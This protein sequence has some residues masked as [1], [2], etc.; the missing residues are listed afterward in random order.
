MIGTGRIKQ[1]RLGK[2]SLTERHGWLIITIVN[3]LEKNR[4]TLR[5]QVTLEH[6]SSVGHAT[7]LPVHRRQEQQLEALSQQVLHVPKN[8]RA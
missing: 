4:D 5:G 3:R 1:D 6:L 2:T 7:S 8:E